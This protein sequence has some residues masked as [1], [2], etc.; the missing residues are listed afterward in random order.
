MADITNA[1]TDVTIFAPDGV[2]A[3]Q[4][5][6]DNEG[7]VYD[8]KVYQKITNLVD[9]TSTAWQYYSDE[10]KA[11]MLVKENGEPAAAT[12]T[13]WILVKNPAASGHYLRIKRF[14]AYIG[15][16]NLA[17]LWRVYKNPTITTNGTALTPRNKRDLSVASEF[18]AYFQPTIS[19][20]GTLLTAFG[21]TTGHIIND[22]DLSLTF[23]ENENMLITLEA[24]L[25]SNPYGITIE[26]AEQEI[27][28]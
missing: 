2:N 16:V 3:M 17:A 23:L 12:E 5:N 18:T 21:A 9:K 15:K 8:D 27:P 6:S 13:D 11:F 7:L 4:V 22:E 26:W 20:R 28:I 24:S 25:K 10:D 1:T 14:M 19:A